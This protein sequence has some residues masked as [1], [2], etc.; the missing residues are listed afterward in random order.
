[1]KISIIVPTLNESSTIGRLIPHL[2]SKQKEDK[3]LIIVD[4]GST[5]GTID[6]VKSFPVKLLHSDASRAKQ[7]NLGASIAQHSNLYFVHADTLPPIDF[8]QDIEDALAKSKSAMCYRSNFVG[9]S[10]MLKLNSF[11]T[12]FGW[13]VSRGGDQS[14][15]VSKSIFLKNGG[16]DEKMEVMEE[17]SL[18]KKLL[19]QK[20]IHLNPKKIAISTRKYSDNSWIKVSRANYIAYKMF[21]KGIASSEIK[22]KYQALLK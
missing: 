10:R 18:F 4:G 19:D 7:M 5:D 2:L 3:E 6:I 21:S 11:F 1:M 16:F 15:F 20:L 14:L 12:R 17:Y 8:Y 22:K 9:G 13:L